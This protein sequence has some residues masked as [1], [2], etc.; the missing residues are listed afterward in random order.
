MDYPNFDIGF[1]LETDTSYQGLGAVLSQKLEDKLL[2]PVLYSSHALSPS[3]KYYAVTELETVAVVWAIKHYRAYLYGHDVQVVTD[4][5]AVKA[6]LANPSPS[7]KH[8]RWWLQVYGSGIRKVEIV[9]RPGKENARA[10]AL[11]R[12][13]TD[14][15]HHHMLDVQVAGVSSWVS[16]IYTLLQDSPG[17]VSPCNFNTEQEKDPELRQLRQFLQFGILPEEEMTARAIAAQAIN[18]EMVDN[19]LYY[20]WIGREGEVV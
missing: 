7:G 20:T 18:F 17:E 14:A 2:H 4:H 8:A 3:E 9:Y 11:S 10:D 6:L 5:T 12:N 15:P 19:V 13:P 16:D 1:V